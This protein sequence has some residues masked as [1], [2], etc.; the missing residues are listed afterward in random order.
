MCHIP[1][2]S[3]LV[4]KNLVVNGSLQKTNKKPN[5]TKW[6]KKLKKNTNSAELIGTFPPSSV[7]FEKA[8]SSTLC[9]NYDIVKE[10]KSQSLKKEIKLKFHENW[11]YKN[12]APQ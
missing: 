11:F 1:Y 4:Q 6:K 10:C 5:Q 9:L 3:H 8:K 12:I 2:I 7:P